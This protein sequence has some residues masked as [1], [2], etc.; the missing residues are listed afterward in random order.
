[1]GNKHKFSRETDRANRM[2]KLKYNIC[3]KVSKRPGHWWTDI[4]QFLEKMYKKRKMT[5]VE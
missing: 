4:E 5:G 1:M 2:Q 3:C